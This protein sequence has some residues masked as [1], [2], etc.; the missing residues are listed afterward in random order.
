[1]DP[2]GHELD[3]LGR[4]VPEEGDEPVRSLVGQAFQHSRIH[5]AEHRRRQ[6]DAEGER[7]NGE[8]AQA[9]ALDQHSRAV[10]DVAEQTVH[11]HLR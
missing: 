2:H 6:A 7:D 10:A 9:R 3:A 1:V 11:G 4:A 8:G 5:N